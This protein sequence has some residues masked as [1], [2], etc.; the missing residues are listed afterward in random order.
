M[1]I[2]SRA[3]RKWVNIWNDLNFGGEFEPV[4]FVG[5]L[6]KKFEEKAAENWVPNGIG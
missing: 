1:A 5:S 6:E 3:G 4:H 2:L